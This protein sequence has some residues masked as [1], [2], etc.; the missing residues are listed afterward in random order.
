MRVP[1]TCVNCG[2]SFKAWHHS[3][4]VQIFCSVG[5]AFDPEP[6]VCEHGYSL[7]E[8]K[9]CLSLKAEPAK[10]TAQQPEAAVEAPV[11]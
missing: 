7:G 4:V 3:G 6:E 10:E 11:E 2:K 1:S 8:C 9:L 5:C